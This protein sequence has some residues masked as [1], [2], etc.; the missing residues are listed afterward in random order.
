MLCKFSFLCCFFYALHLYFV[1]MDN[2][3]DMKNAER[4]RLTIRAPIA[5][6]R[7]ESEGTVAARNYV[8]RSCCLDMDSRALLFF[9]QLVISLIVLV[10]CIYEIAVLDDAQWAKMTGTFILGVW[11]PSPQGQ[12]IAGS[13]RYG[14]CY[15]TGHPVSHALRTY[16]NS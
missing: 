6:V 4:E 16:Q 13:G 9:S 1:L 5:L 8:W 12:Q 7:A 15:R 11:L 3:A 10:F 14:S 2:F